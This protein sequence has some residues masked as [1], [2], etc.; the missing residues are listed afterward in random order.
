[1]ILKSCFKD[2]NLNEFVINYLRA[3]KTKNRDQSLH[4]IINI[5]FSGFLAV[6]NAMKSAQVRNIQR[7]V[8]QSFLIAESAS[9]LYNT[10][11]D[12]KTK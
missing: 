7:T 4:S 8:G 11:V 2:D 1:L 9:H 10:H 6:T 12:W 3:K 5:I